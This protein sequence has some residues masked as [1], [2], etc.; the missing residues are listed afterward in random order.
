MPDNPTVESHGRWEMKGERRNEDTSLSLEQ[1]LS[2]TPGIQ[3]T[4]GSVKQLGIS[5]RGVHLIHDVHHL[6]QCILFLAF[7]HLSLMT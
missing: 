5:E 7:H 4:A 1:E 3:R 2:L 6:H